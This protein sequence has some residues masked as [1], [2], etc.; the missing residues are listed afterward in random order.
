MPTVLSRI[1]GLAACAVLACSPTPPDPR[2]LFERA[3]ARIERSSV[4][5]YE[6]VT[7][8]SAGRGLEGRATLERLDL[9]GSR[10]R[11]R[12]AGRDR[13]G[14]SFDVAHDGVEVRSLDA[15]TRTLWSSPL[16]AAGPTL[17]ARVQAALMYPFFDP[18]PTSPST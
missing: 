18:R 17:L 3:A 16:A 7:R 13:E 9:S 5:E 10:Y 12:V 2:A 8:D 14:S 6:F 1:A 11:A 4:F 15:E